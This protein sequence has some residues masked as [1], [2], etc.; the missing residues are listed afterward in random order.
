MSPDLDT[1]AA[2]AATLLDALDA[3]EDDAYA[4]GVPE[5]PHDHAEAIYDAKSVL[6]DALSAIAS[7]GGAVTGGCRVGGEPPMPGVGWGAVSDPT[8][9]VSLLRCVVPMGSHWVA[10]GYD[11]DRISDDNVRALYRPGDPA[12]RP[13][14]R[15]E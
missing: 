12:D 1:L 13:Y 8:F 14:W 15:R 5:Y 7:R 11:R 4:G 3:H 10:Y 2:L 9:G 6:R